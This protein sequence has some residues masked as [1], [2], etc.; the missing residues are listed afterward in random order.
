MISD[1]TKTKLESDGQKILSEK[2]FLKD[3]GV[4]IGNAKNWEGYRAL[5]TKKLLVPFAQPASQAELTTDE[6]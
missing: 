5:R 6:N 1:V 2:E 3:L 4:T